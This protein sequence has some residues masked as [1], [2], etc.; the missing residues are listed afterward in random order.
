MSIRFNRNAHVSVFVFV[1][2]AAAILSAACAAPPPPRVLPPTPLTDSFTTSSDEEW[3]VYILPPNTPIETVETE[4]TALLPDP[5]NDDW[6][7]E[8]IGH[9]SKIQFNYNNRLPLT[10]DD[11]LVRSTRLD[12]SDT[13]LADGLLPHLIGRVG[14]SCVESSGEAFW[15]LDKTAIST[16]LADLDPASA[17]WESVASCGE[18]CQDC[19]CIGPMRGP[20][21]PAS[22]LPLYPV[23]DAATE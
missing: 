9:M 4:L 14:A 20:T 13:E 3:Q 23:L 7:A 11:A 21:C 22:F 12:I 18:E 8:S 19:G 10:T 15:I 17:L 5:A 16:L 2:F 1:C 6:L